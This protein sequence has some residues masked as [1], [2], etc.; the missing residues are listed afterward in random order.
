M[1]VTKTVLL[2]TI[3]M[4]HCQMFNTKGM[5]METMIQM[6]NIA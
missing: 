4:V 1:S 5:K 3:L 2:E 6:D